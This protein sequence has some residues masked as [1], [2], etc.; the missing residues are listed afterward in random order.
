MA[1]HHPGATTAP[2]P[3]LVPPILATW[4]S[5]FRPCFTAP[6]WNRILVLVAGAVLAP[7]K[8]TVTQ[9]LR[10]MGLADEP[11][12]RRYHEVLSRARW[13]GQ[14]VARRLLLYII[15]R[16]LPDGE[17]VVGI[18]DTIERRWGA[19]ISARGI[20]RDPVRSSKGHFVKTSGLRWLSLMVAVPIP[21]AKRTW[22]LPF[23]TILAPSARWSEANG[24]RHKTLTT[25]ARQ[26]ILQTKRWLPN[27]RLVFVADSG[28]AA[29]DLLAAVRSHVCMI[30]RLRLDANLFWPAPKRRPGQRGRT[31]L[32][33]R[34][35]AEAE[36]VLKNKKTVWTSVVVSQWY[37]AQQRRL[38]VTTG[39]AL[40]YRA[41]S[42]TPPRPRPQPVPDHRVGQWLACSP[43]RR[44]GQT[45]PDVPQAVLDIQRRHRRRSPRALVP[46]GL[47][48]SRQ[49][50]EVIE[51][52]AT[53][54]NRVLP[55]S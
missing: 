54:L 25:W 22:A 9:V 23:L 4:L 26:A 8:R 21:W 14:A 41:G 44:C 7:G 29:L 10:V 39:T 1:S 11:S 27:R 18:D 19:R 38:L 2:D 51:I 35:F 37:N 17:V 28:F 42:S 24:K 20:Y 6:V 36:C 16:L 30:T 47:S 50:G 15:E 53:L 46:A 33:G 13:D 48:M 55:D 5:V 43:P 49:P 52:P 32:K 45:P 40:W 12:F 31:P 34:G 3:H